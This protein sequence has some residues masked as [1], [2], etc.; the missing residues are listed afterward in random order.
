MNLHSDT[1]C[2]T[3]DSKIALPRSQSRPK[4]TILLELFAATMRFFGHRSLFS[5]ARRSLSSADA[6]PVLKTPLYDVHVEAGA[7]MVPFSSYAMPLQYK[8]SS[9]FASFR[10]DQSLE[11]TNLKCY[12]IKLSGLQGA[13]MIA[14]HNHTRTKA[15]L[16]DVAHMGPCRCKSPVEALILPPQNAILALSHGSSVQDFR[17]GSD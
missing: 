1:R 9:P 8:V 7:K 3:F 12:I 15:S 4:N 10:C 11:I 13:G 2:I 16:F 17:Q 14:E 6:G 5:V